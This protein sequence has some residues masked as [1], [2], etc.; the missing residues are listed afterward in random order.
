MREKD[1]RFRIH[2]ADGLEDEEIVLLA[3]AAEQRVHRPR[4]RVIRERQPLR[5]LPRL[6]FE[7]LR[8]KCG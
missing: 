4:H 1:R 3:I 6:A 8:E 5:S 7:L 2:G